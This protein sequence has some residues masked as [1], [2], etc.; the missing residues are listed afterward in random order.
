MDTKTALDQVTAAES[1]VCAMITDARREAQDLLLEAKRRQERRM[2]ETGK[3]AKEEAE[4]WRK[5]AEEELG[6]EIA[7]LQADS[8]R[9]IDVMRKRA[10]GRMKRALDFLKSRLD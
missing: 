7:D 8:R 10:G 4:A 3:K 6:R 9:Q 1:R 2:E 5:K